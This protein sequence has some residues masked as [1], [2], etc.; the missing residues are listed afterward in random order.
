LSSENHRGKLGFGGLLRGFR[1]RSGLTQQALGK[2]ISVSKPVISHY[3]CGFRLPSRQTM[4]KIRDV[5][6]LTSEEYVS[7]MD[8]ANG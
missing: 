6:E 1:H 8:A 5:L 4:G 3:E 7:L 2:L